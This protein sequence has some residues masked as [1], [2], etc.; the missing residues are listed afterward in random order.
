MLV[1]AKQLQTKQRTRPEEEEEL[2][3]ELEELEELEEDE[4][5]EEEQVVDS[6][7]LWIAFHNLHSWRQNA[8]R[9]LGLNLLKTQLAQVCFSHKSHCTNTEGDCFSKQIPHSLSWTNGVGGGVTG[10][11]GGEVGVGV[12]TTLKAGLNNGQEGEGQGE[13]PHISD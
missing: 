7:E 5:L 9:N 10:L 13:G 4:E 3:E 8:H 2:E 12:G 1:Q 6:F 11:G